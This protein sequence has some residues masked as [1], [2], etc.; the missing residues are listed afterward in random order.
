M[1]PSCLWIEPNVQTTRQQMKDKRE[2][3]KKRNLSSFSATFC[4]DLHTLL[5]TWT[6]GR[7]QGKRQKQ[8]ARQGS[9]AEIFAPRRLLSCRCRHSATKTIPSTLIRLHIYV[10]E[11]TQ[12]SRHIFV[13][14]S[15]FDHG[16]SGAGSSRERIASRNSFVDAVCRVS[17][18]HISMR[19]LYL[20][21][22]YTYIA[23]SDAHA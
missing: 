2:R 6:Y 9:R 21:S 13:P 14:V 23:L 18:V 22:S 19:C 15:A 5:R 20:R 11:R 7:G 4:R 8:K 12:T 16:K 3:E 10:P 17:E 1:R